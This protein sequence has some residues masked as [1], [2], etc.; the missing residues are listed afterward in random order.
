[1]G[2]SFMRMKDRKTRLFSLRPGRESNSRI[3]VLSRYA[4][5]REA[6]QTTYFIWR[7]GRESNSRIRVLQTLA[8]PLGYQAV[9]FL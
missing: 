3:R 1:M 5:S 6:R 7:P 2:L 4:G 9:L 8:L